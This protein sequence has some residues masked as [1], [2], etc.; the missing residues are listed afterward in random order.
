M[1]TISRKDLARIIG[2]KTR[3]MQ[4]KQEL[5][6]AI[7]AYLTVEKSKIDIDSL[8]RDVMQYRQDQGYVEAVA[9]S[10]HPLDDEVINDIK[11]LLR[12][13]FPDAKSIV[14]SQRIDKFVVGG[15]R[16]ELPQEDLDLSIRSKLNL[17][18]RL[19]SLE[20]N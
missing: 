9:V 1:Q 6:E 20:R 15:V 11:D 5:V 14:V 18:K 17:F 8:V 7:A 4:S 16:I 3:H 13:R 2:E 19:A 12:E 10:A